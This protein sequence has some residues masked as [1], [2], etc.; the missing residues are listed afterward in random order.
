MWPLDLRLF[1][2]GTL[3]TTDAGNAES[4]ALLPSADHLSRIND[5]AFVPCVES[6]ERT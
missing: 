1:I 2:Y 6:A 3:R 5:V 4:S